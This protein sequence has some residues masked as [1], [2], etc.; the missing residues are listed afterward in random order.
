MIAENIRSLRER[1]QMAC[2]R[3]GR[4]SGE[5]Q[6]IAVSKTVSPDRIRQAVECGIY[7][8]GENYVQELNLKKKRVE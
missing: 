8:F 4:K 6:L 1:I 7:D 2:S 3:C 5:I